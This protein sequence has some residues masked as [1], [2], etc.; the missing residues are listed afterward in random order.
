MKKV[1]LYGK[2]YFVNQ[3]YHYDEIEDLGIDEPDNSIGYYIGNEKIDVD[4]YTLSIIK[5]SK[6]VTITNISK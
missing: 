6:G 3:F 5:T 4:G 2:T 1:I